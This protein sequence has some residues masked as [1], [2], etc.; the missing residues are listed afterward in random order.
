[1]SW[2]WEVLNGL[3]RRGHWTDLAA[4][5]LTISNQSSKQG[6][7]CYVG[8][9]RRGIPLPLWS[10][11]CRL[12]GPAYV[13]ALLLKVRRWS[14]TIVVRVC[15]WIRW[16]GDWKPLNL[17]RLKDGLN[18]ALYAA[19]NLQ[20]PFFHHPSS[21]FLPNS[22]PPP[23]R[24]ASSI[25]LRFN[26]LS[27]ECQWDYIYVFDGDSIYAPKI[28]AFTWVASQLFHGSTVWSVTWNGLFRTQYYILYDKHRNMPFIWCFLPTTHSHSPPTH[29]FT[30]SPHTPH[31][32]R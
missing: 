32:Q 18:W 10:T 26:W 21:V 29:T 20:Q 12:G 27:A 23:L 1:M 14:F 30:P 8:G 28:A 11:V 3:P 2:L 19:V 4:Y 24:P 7:L 31:T 22:L 5:T 6:C 16:G 25:Q 17:W 9:G 13:W 15:V